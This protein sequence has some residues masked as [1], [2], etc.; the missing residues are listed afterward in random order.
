MQQQKPQN[1]NEFDQPTVR[2]LPRL[3]RR[4][5][6]IFFV[7]LFVL[8]V[9]IFVFYATGYRF[10]IFEQDRGV[11]VTGG[12]YVGNLT[13]RS[14]IY[15]NDE[16]VRGSR[17]FR[18]GT[19]IQN[20]FPGVQKV[21]VQAPGLQTWVKKVPVLP[22]IVTEVE[23]F[24]MPEIPQVRLI[25]EYQDATGRAVVAEDSLA[26]STLASASSTS[27]FVLA[28][29]TLQ[30]TYTSNPEYLLVQDLFEP[31]TTSVPSA[32][33]SPSN[34]FGFVQS[35]VSVA[36]TA[37]TSLVTTT[38]I[39]GGMVLYESDNQLFVRYTG[40]VRAIPHYYCVPT[41]TVASTTEL[42]GAHVAYEIER[43]LAGPIQVITETY[44]TNQRLCRNEIR[45]DTR[46][47]TP[48]SFYFLPNFTD[49][50]L[51]HLDE[52]V[53]VVEVD[54][55]SWQNVQQV[56]P[57]SAEKVLVNNNRIYIKEEDVFFELYTTLLT[58]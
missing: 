10:D 12:L 23:A 19:Y 2:P 57:A 26:L 32:T 15:V 53:F 36:T 41:A 18:R 20:V 45:I 55:R 6:F 58:P 42:Y 5:I 44:D 24:L 21:H 38:Q 22:Y 16:L 11:V 39:R 30:R 8:C 17:L 9:P 35:D 50:I 51:V 48:L 43:K 14:D 3:Y 49:Y 46:F 27:V 34:R 1:N 25:T 7:L 4:V 47:Q 29:T 56:Y 31:A 54:D 40:A 33:S 13:E 37:T 28:S 52:G